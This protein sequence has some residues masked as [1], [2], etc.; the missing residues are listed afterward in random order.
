MSRILVS[1]MPFAGHVAPVTGVVA[2]LVARGHRVTV[3]TGSRYVARFE[4]L[5]AATL[6]WSAAADFD[7]H[8]LPATFPRVGRR[9][10]LGVLANLEHI[11]IRT[12]TGQARDMAAA[13]Q[14]EPFDLI[15]GDVLSLGTGLA[16]E[17]LGLPWVTLSIVPLSLP[18]VDLPALGGAPAAVRLIENLISSGEP[19]LREASP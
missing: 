16:A 9:G 17:L 14:A 8:D 3:Y 12:G 18:S 11:F 15:V 6:P 1:V 2:E 10:P 7:E 13:H 19:V 4:S 5:G